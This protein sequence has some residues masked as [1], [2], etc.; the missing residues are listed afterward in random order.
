MTEAVEILAGKTEAADDNSDETEAA[1]ILAGETEAVDDLTGETETAASIPSGSEAADDN[2]NES[3]A[4]VGGKKE[5]IAVTGGISAGAMKIFACLIMMLDHI[6]AGYIYYGYH[7]DNKNIEHSADLRMLYFCIRMVGRLAFP[8]FCFFIVEGYFRTRNVWKYLRNMVIFGLISEFPYDWALNNKYIYWNNQNVY[9]TLALGLLMVIIFDK[10]TRGDFIKAGIKKQIAAIV[11]S[12]LPIL[13]GFLLETD[14]G[15]LGV[16]LIFT[17]Y[18]FRKYKK[19]GVV[20]IILTLGFI[21]IT[22]LFACFDFMLFEK[23]N[24]KKGISMKYFFY[25]FYPV[26]L[27]IIAV[28]RYLVFK[29]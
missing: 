23:Y 1:E 28:V 15:G 19:L 14:Y 12:S 13:A 8:I 3:D 22:E 9:F 20:S 17:F 7:L 29:V 2:L 11:L 26:H 24:G 4:S 16:L 27:L 5:K 18:I 21:N 10:I 25:A 6:G